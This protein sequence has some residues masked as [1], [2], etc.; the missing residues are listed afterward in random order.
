MWVV[1]GLYLAAHTTAGDPSM[2]CWCYMS[3][4]LQFSSPP[5]RP[6]WLSI[7]FRSSEK[8][9]PKCGTTL[10]KFNKDLYII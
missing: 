8:V 10:A 7:N 9:G 6:K 5:K 4:A 3:A 1:T 2:C